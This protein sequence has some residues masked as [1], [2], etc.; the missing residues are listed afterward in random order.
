MGPVE[1]VYMGRGYL[2]ISS[3][4][5]TIWVPSRCVKPVVEEKK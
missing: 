4:T 2:C 5:G 1:V 3:P